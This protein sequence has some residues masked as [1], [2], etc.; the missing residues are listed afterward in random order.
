LNEEPYIYLLDYREIKLRI[1]VR[2]TLQP[3]LFVFY[4]VVFQLRVVIRSRHDITGITFT[5]KTCNMRK[6]Y[7]SNIANTT[8]LSYAHAH[9]CVDGRKMGFRFM[10]CQDTQRIAHHNYYLRNV[11]NELI[12]PRI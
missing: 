6:Q 7:Q 10:K 1:R 11:R 8:Y 3:W 2:N 9:I 12:F 5:P 4:K